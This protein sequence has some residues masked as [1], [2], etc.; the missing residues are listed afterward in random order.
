MALPL[1]SSVLSRVHVHGAQGRSIEAGER[2][3]A[4]PREMSPK[5]KPEAADQDGRGR[6][7][8]PRLEEQGEAGVSSLQPAGHMWPRMAMNVAH[9][10]IVKLLKTL[11]FFLL[12]GFR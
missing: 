4:F 10:K 1:Q 5:L 8:S 7:G 2:G 6:W 11:F 12:I 9:H 3:V